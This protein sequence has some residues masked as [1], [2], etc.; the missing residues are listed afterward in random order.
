MYFQALNLYVIFLVGYVGGMCQI[1]LHKG[2]SNI[3]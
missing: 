1:D 3:V 2:M